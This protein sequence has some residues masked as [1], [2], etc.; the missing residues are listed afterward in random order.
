MPDGF[1]FP[2]NNSM[3]QPLSLLPGITR[4]PRDS[5]FL[6]AIGRLAD[7]VGAAEAA[8]ELNAINRAI[9]RD[10]PE[11]NGRTRAAVG[12]FRPGIGDPWYV[13]FGALMTA[14]GLLL[15]VSCANVANLL[16]ARSLQRAGE[17]SIR[18]SLG[19]T[20]WRV[21]RQLLVE[22]VMLSLVAG[23]VALLLSMAAI[24]WLLVFVEE[25]GK[26]AWMDFSMDAT[27]FGFLAAV[28]VGTGMLFGVAPA[29]YISRR[30]GSEMLKQS[31][32]RTATAGGWARR[33]MSALVVAEVVLTIV[34]VSGAVSMMRHLH[35]QVVASRA[36]DTSRLLTLNV[37]L[38]AQ[39]YPG[40]REQ[41]AFVRRLEERLLTTGTGASIAIATSR[42]YMGGGN[43]RVS[44]DGHAPAP[45]ERLPAVQ[46]VTIGSNYFEVLG[47]RLTR[48]RTITAEGGASGDEVVVDERFVEEFLPG[49]EPLGRS[50]TL[51]LDGVAH[52]VTIAGVAP[53]LRRDETGG[54]PTTRL[55]SVVY[56][57]YQLHPTSGLVLLARSGTSTSAVAARLRD[58]VRALDADLPLFNIRYSRG[59]TQRAALGESRVRR[60]VRNL[61]LYRRADRDGRHLR[62]RGLRD[63]SAHAGDWHSHGARSAAMA[64]VVDD[65]AREGCSDCAGHHPGRGRGVS[66]AAPHG[67]A[68]CR[69]VRPGSADTCHQCGISP[70]RLGCRDALAR[71]ARNVAQP[72]RRRCGTNRQ[73]RALCHR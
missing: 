14:V 58:E 18:V 10:F 68:A 63:E 27:V 29:F 39:K 6:G 1:E 32:T 16:L 28:C 4:E 21:V 9:A 60:H 30:A 51:H 12:R 13:V 7:G 69:T 8:A 61:R 47:L 22:S 33:W 15:L 44:I 24:Q 23:A 66:A 43:G 35:A 49:V 57:P 42:P 50:M 54:S 64:I 40:G 62:R 53:T 41:I 73:A 26:P 70:V 59:R 25:I 56:V 36:F 17:V 55:V 71:L 31:S 38:S 3:W 2:F 11:T 34:L 65:D 72:S 46:T 19:A 67:R 5:R 48:G 52:Q 20:R 45:G 37:S